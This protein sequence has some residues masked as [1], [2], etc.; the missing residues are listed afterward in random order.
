MALIPL[1]SRG[2]PQFSEMQIVGG[3]EDD[4][5]FLFPMD[6][7]PRSEQ[8]DGYMKPLRSLVLH[9]GDENL[10][11][12][13]VSL[14]G[15]VLSLFPP[16]DLSSLEEVQ[17]PPTSVVAALLQRSRNSV[18]RLTLLSLLY[19]FVTDLHGVDLWCFYAD[20]YYKAV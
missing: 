12:F 2:G 19:I 16:G 10:S 1:F 3:F 5:G 6:P 8:C 11:P 13:Q 20:H 17:A 14:A 18:R 7:H 4:A 9:C 15:Q